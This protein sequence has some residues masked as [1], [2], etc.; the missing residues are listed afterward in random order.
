[1]VCLIG[2]T[3]GR[4]AW[5][6]LGSLLL[7]HLL[8]DFH[9]QGLWIAEGKGL[10]P[11][12]L[13]VHTGTRGLLMAPVLFLAGGNLQWGLPFLVGTHLVVDL[14]KARGLWEGV[15]PMGWP[16]WVDQGLHT[17]TLIAVVPW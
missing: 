9:W 1:M 15:D 17:L 14:W 4:S 7:L 8:Y 11:L 3:P 5:A 16:L 6:T 12:L 10:H 2:R 13:L